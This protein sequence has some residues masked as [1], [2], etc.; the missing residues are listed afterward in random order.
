MR[1]KLK[2]IDIRWLWIFLGLLTILISFLLGNQSLLIENVYSRGIFLLIRTIMDHTIGLIPVPFLYVL[3]ALLLL[4]IFVKI[5]KGIRSEYTILQKIGSAILTT[6]ALIGGAIFLFQFLWGFNYSRLSLETQLNIQPKALSLEELK[7]ELDL[8]TSI[9]SKKRSVVANVDSFAFNDSYL[10]KNMQKQIRKE[11]AYVLKN[12]GYPSSSRPPLRLLRPKGFLL[13]ISTAGF[14]LPFT[15]ECN[16]DAGLHATQ[17]PFVM[18]HEYAHAYG[19]TDEGSCNF[20][21][22]L[23]CSNSSDPFIQ[24]SGY[25]NYWRYL[26]S[27]Y[28]YLKRKEYDVFRSQLPI[29]IINDLDAIN[30]N[31]IKY[32]DI[33]PEI[34]NAT[35]DAYLKTQGISEGLESYNRIVM[36]VKAWNEKEKQETF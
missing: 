6:V 17:I 19:I 35:Y 1:Q 14:Y 36:L 23:S 16:V 18:A 11:L 4:F 21:A 30:E 34:R 5:K 8:N 22:Y 32:P 10:P 2:N 15:G 25:L 31:F 3:I 24:Y 9:L 7:S 27:D 33:F 29:G 28:R 12:L 13:R 20:L 26:A